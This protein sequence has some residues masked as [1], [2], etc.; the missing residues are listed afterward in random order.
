MS[1]ADLTEAARRPFAGR[2]VRLG[3]LLLEAISGAA[4]AAATFLVV[5]V[6]YGTAVVVEADA[7]ATPPAGE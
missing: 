1:A 5:L 7:T 4:A 6:A 2:R 3:D